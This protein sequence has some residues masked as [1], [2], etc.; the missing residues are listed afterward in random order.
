MPFNLKAF[1]RWSSDLHTR[2]ESLASFADSAGAVIQDGSAVWGDGLYLILHFDLMTRGIQGQ[3][4]D[5][6]KVY[7][8]LE[9]TV[10]DNGGTR[11]GG[12]VYIVPLLPMRRSEACASVF[13]NLMAKSLNGWLV[14]GDSFYLHYSPDVRN[15]MGGIAQV[16]PANAT[17]LT[18]G[19]ES[20]S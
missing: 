7:E 17:S 14:A 2:Q 20:V 11:L 5:R 4:L 19:V 10:K 9:S 13:W 18:P 1:F 16:V 3:E 8:F 15:L 6:S 12:S